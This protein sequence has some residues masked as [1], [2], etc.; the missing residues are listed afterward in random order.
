MQSHVS[1]M[2][3]GVHAQASKAPEPVVAN[4]AVLGNVEEPIETQ[5][6]HCHSRLFK[7]FDFPREFT[8]C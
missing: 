7:L 6:D 8:V 4:C 1:S 3:G 2:I 5:L